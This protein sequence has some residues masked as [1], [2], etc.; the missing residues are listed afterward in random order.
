MV[1]PTSQRTF[2]CSKPVGSFD[3]LVCLFAL[4]V[5]LAMVAI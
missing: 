4:A 2:D 3:N 5:K 1:A